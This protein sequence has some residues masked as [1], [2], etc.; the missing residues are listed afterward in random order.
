MVE[1][2]VH[3]REEGIQVCDSAPGVPCVV[4]QQTELRLLL[5]FSGHSRISTDRR[6]RGEKGREESKHTYRGLMVHGG[7]CYAGVAP[8]RPLV[9]RC[10]GRR[11]TEAKKSSDFCLLCS[12]RREIGTHTKEN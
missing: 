11:K 9:T 5:L 1:V 3:I 10:G 4:F 6:K 2:L 8:C 12:S 7:R